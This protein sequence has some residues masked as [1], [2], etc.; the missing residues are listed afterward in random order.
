MN[1]D[2]TSDGRITPIYEERLLDIGE[3]LS[4]NGDSIYGTKPWTHQNETNINVWYTAKGPAV[5]AIVSFWPD[6]N[7]LELKM[8]RHLFENEATVT[9][10]GNS[11]KVKWEK[12]GDLVKFHFPNK[13]TAKSHIIIVFQ[14]ITKMSSLKIILVICILYNVVAMGNRIRYEPNWESLD[15]RPLPQW[16]DDAKFGIFLHWG[17]YS[18]PSFGSEW[19]WKSW[20]GKFVVIT[21]LILSMPIKNF[22][23]IVLYG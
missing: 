14:T 8:V 19:F 15:T 20:K 4:I 1:A 23:S 13:A 6:G 3:W 2:P 18:V 12:S 21:V 22:L 9:L 5:Y 17:V 7:L 11:G 16:Y 10:L